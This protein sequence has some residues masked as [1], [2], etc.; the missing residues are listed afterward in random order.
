MRDPSPERAERLATGAG[1]FATGVAGML[2]AFSAVTG[3]TGTSARHKPPARPT[4]TPDQA[5]SAATRRAKPAD[6]APPAHEVREGDDPWTAATRAPRPAP[7]PA[8]ATTRAAAEQA[9]AQSDVDEAAP[10]DTG[11]WVVTA[12]GSVTEPAADHDAVAE[13]PTTV[14]D[15]RDQGD[16]WAAA[17]RAPKRP[18]PT[19][20]PTTAAGA[21]TARAA[22]SASA[23]PTT[24]SAGSTRS[25]PH[26]DP[27]AAVGESV[28]R[29]EEGR[30]TSGNGTDHPS[31]PRLADNGGG[32][33]RRVTGAT[34][35]WAAATA[36]NGD[37]GGDTGVADT[38]SVDHDVAGT[39]PGSA[40]AGG[41]GAGSGD[42]A[43]AGDAV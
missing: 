31:S 36:A 3:T 27:V 17:T 23:R 43:R 14:T 25:D 24:G 33:S 12:G 20:K 13:P 30:K 26:R 21:A 18:V 6:P 37:T 10:S 15:A 7:A 28:A 2:R 4:T 38:P 8:S 35:V 32:G 22:T 1:D 41:R 11:A 40:E 34:D 29:T 39:A 5:W 9:A 16:P 19:R 42:G